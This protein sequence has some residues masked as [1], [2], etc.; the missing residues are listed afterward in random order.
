[1]PA[2]A[3][4]SR[5]APAAPAA[6]Q[7]AAARH[8]KSCSRPS[9]RPAAQPARQA[10]WRPAAAAPRPAT[11]PAAA[12]TE[13]PARARAPTDIEYDAVIIGSGM[14]GLST[15]AQMAC[16]GAKVVVLEK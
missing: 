14:G 9:T 1:M 5:P 4:A 12:A 3:L 13:A 16:K 8:Q 6:P 10:G 11:R 2:S 15:A 7:R